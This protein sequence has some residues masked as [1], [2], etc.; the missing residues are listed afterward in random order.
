MHTFKMKL[1]NQNWLKYRESVV[2]AVGAQLRYIK[3][4]QQ[5]VI[6]ITLPHISNMFDYPMFSF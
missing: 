4:N 1:S 5:I 6:S 2:E 3:I